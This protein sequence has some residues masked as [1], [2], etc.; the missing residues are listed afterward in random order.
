MT[1]LK[2]A[3]GRAADGA[4]SGYQRMPQRLTMTE[5]A[6]SALPGDFVAGAPSSSEARED[7]LARAGEAGLSSLRPS[8]MRWLLR[9]VWQ[10][11]DYSELAREALTA[12]LRRQRRSFDY[13]IV[14]GY[15]EHFPVGH[16]AFEQ[17]VAAVQLVA[18]RHEWPW[19]RRGRDWNL[20]Q[21]REGPRLLGR[22]LVL[23]TKSPIEILRSA[24]FDEN[25]LGARF[26]RACFDA[27]CRIAAEG[28][29]AV[30]EQ[31]GKR[32]TALFD[33]IDAGGRLPPVLIYALLNPWQSEN[34]TPEHRARLMRLLIAHVGDPR[35]HRTRWD[36]IA[37]RMRADVPD[38][39]VVGA[40]NVF[41][42]WVVQ[43]AVRQFFEI[44][45]ST[46]NDRQ[47]WAER[48][49]F[50]LGYLDAGF[51]EDA[52]FALGP[53]AEESARTVRR[54]DASLDYGRITTGGSAESS[55]SAL[56][57][58]M[59][60]LRIAEWSHNGACRF[61]LRNDRSA[62]AQYQRQYDSG[63]LKAMS[64][65]GGFTYIRHYSGWQPKFARHIHDHTAI[66][67]PVHGRGW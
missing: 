64:G 67:H 18:E 21:P 57:I 31:Q 54:H 52:W 62:P 49:K 43:T 1:H 46:T 58:S 3:I 8:E 5:R 7:F 17:L 9:T 53:R 45:D 28:K 13:S 19:K 20:W 38:Q 29:G 30:A 51:I 27:A 12:G 11:E 63:R 4:A 48:T 33:R 47:Q 6:L 60:D 35:L 14:S 40:L 32:L 61:W 16:P 65:G 34:P 42:R 23:E 22:A 44:V 36:S 50:W 25:S 2:Q 10:D 55:H 37:D 24:G 56:L 15:L 41:R 66:Q 39:D 26:V 59:G